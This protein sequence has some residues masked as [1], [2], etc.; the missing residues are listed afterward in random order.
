MLIQ[1]H[2]EIELS[3]SATKY[4][5]H[6]RLEA[7]ECRRPVGRLRVGEKKEQKSDRPAPARSTDTGLV[8]EMKS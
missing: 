2:V 7:R 3:D 8:H 1:D 4:V 5:N 6:F